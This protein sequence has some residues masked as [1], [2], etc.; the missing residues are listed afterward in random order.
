MRKVGAEEKVETEGGGQ[1]GCGTRQK[2]VTLS[3]GR[4]GLRSLEK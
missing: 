1:T 2:G 4:S 3:T